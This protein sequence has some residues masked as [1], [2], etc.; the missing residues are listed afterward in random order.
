MQIENPYRVRLARTPTPIQKL[1]RLSKY[2]KGPSIYIKRDDLT[3][4]GLSGNKV[5][6]LEYSIGE[7]V[8][9]KSDILITTGGTT[10]NHARATALAARQ[11]GLKPYLVLRGNPEKIPDGNLLF[12]II[13][14]AEIKFITPEQYLKRDEIMQ[15]LADDLRQKGHRP[16]VIPEGASNAIGCWG[17]FNAASEIRD[18]LLNEN[19]PEMDAIVIAVG[20]GGTQAGLLLGLQ[21]HQLDIPVYGINVCDDEKYFQ[22]K[23]S[24]LLKSFGERFSYPL[25][26][27]EDIMIIDGYVGKGYARSRPEEIDVIRLLAK[28]EGILLD[29]VYTGKAMFGLIDQIKTGKFRKETNIL[30]IHT[31]GIFGLFP[32][33]EAFVNPKTVS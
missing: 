4:F 16:Y 19:L 1:S 32:E 5:R 21:Y 29:P 8:Q 9:K 18:Q 13:L 27:P 28:L 15:E 23:I 24:E 2:L 25:S 11:L 12:D 6:K 22:Q 14:D 26:L 20:S 3:G 17:Y 33:R 7:A 10:S 30:F 31:G